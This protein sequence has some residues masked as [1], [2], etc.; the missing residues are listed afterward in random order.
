MLLVGLGTILLCATP[1]LTADQW[2]RNGE[3][4]APDKA[5]AS[6]GGFAVQQIATLDSD[7]LIERWSQPTDGVF[8]E[9]SSIVVRNQ[10]IFTYIVFTGCKPDK[11]GACNVT[12]VFKMFDPKRKPWGS[13]PDTPI[14]VG[15]PAPAHGI[16][17]LSANALGMVV[18][19]KDALGEYRVTADVTDHVAGIT[20]HTAKVLTA[21]AAKQAG[22]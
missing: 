16:L 22:Q 19:D 6:S 17:Q 11:A 18:E 5:L 7:G 8:I 20:L 15:L 4:A 13:Q 10:P 1:G 12:A 9:S 14:W 3:P 21:V 2:Q